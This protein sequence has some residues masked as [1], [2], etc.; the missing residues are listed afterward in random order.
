MQAKGEDWIFEAKDV[1]GLSQLSYR[2]FVQL[3]AAD[4][5][6]STGSSWS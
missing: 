5:A 3:P 4:V 1:K 6:F 2:I